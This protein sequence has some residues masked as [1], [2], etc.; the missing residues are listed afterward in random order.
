MFKSELGTLKGYEAKI[1]VDSDAQPRFH[2]ARPVPYTMKSEVEAELDRLQKDGIIEPVQF[3]DWAAP[4]VAVLKSDGKSVRICGDFK[5]TINQASKLDQYPRKIQAYQQ[6]LLEENSKRFVVINTHRGLFRYNRLP[7]GVASAPGIFQR[8]MESLLSG[9]PG[10]VVYIDDIL[11]TGKTEADHLVA[12]EEVLKRIE[13]AGLRLKKEKCAFLAPSVVYLGYKVDAQGIHPV[14]EKVKA[15]QEA[16]RPKNVTELKSYLGLLMYYSR[17][18]PNLSDTLAPLYKLLKRHMHWKWTDAQEKAFTRSK[19]SLLSSQ[20]LVHFDPTLNIT[21]A[22]DASAYGIGAVLSHQ[23]P[24]G[25]EKP[26]GFVSRTLSETERRY[27]QIEKEGLACV[28]G[29]KRFHAYL[30]GHHFTLQTDHKP[31]MTLFNESKEIPTQ[32]SGRIR[33][34]ALTL[35]AYEYTLACRTTKKHANADALSCHYKFQTPSQFQLSSC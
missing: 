30:F 34:W 9:I 6:L 15:I 28:F 3:A 24:D 29:V 25:L 10:V 21:L 18:L 32:A 17:F 23:M 26:V 8:V 7:F 5:V 11:I 1:L 4:I 14:A 19:E 2:K 35:A 12:L 16:P 22:C 33:R 31:L 13:N 20:L 27:S